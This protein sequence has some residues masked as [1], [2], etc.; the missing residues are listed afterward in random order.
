MIFSIG[1]DMRNA[2]VLLA[3]F[4]MY[5]VS[6]GAKHKRANSSGHGIYGEA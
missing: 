3:K 2:G 5:M 4:K 1:V 6:M